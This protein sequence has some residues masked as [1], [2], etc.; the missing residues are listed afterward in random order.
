[1]EQLIFLIFSSKENILCFHTSFVSAHL[2]INFKLMF[3]YV[4]PSVLWLP[5]M[6][7]LLISK[8]W[9]RVPLT[10]MLS[11]LSHPSFVTHQYNRF[12]EDTLI[13]IPFGP[14]YN[15]ISL[16]IP[17][18]MYWGWNG[19]LEFVSFIWWCIEANNMLLGA[20]FLWIHV[21]MSINIHGQNWHI[22]WTIVSCSNAQGTIS[23][24]HHQLCHIVIHWNYFVAHAH[25]NLIVPYPM[26]Q[27]TCIFFVHTQLLLE[28]IAFDSSSFC[29]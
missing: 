26:V 21:L 24:P 17:N 29:S 9:R 15:Y 11:I 19:R 8:P 7:N 6:Q 23:L 4:F 3:Y 13:L 2:R 18:A 22:E 1:M 14:I 27:S 12:I 16:F 28:I 10:E 20:L 5:A 25:L